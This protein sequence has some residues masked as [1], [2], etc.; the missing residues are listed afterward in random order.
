MSKNGK[1]SINGKEES[2]ERNPGRVPFVFN[3]P[4][5]RLSFFMDGYALQPQGEQG[6]QDPPSAQE[7]VGS[8][9]F[10]LTS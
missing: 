2:Y 7:M 10:M 1:N 3:Q 9:V 5:S 4:F 6:P 8:Q